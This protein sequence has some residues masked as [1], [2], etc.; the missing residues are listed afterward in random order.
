MTPQVEHTDV[1]AYALGLLEEDDRRAFEA[2]LEQCAACVAELRDMSGMAELFSGLDEFT[3]VVHDL[4]R[5]A[6]DGGPAETP[7][8]RSAVER[9]D[10]GRRRRAERRYRR[11]TYLI[12]AAAAAVLIGTGFTVGAGLDD[13]GSGQGGHKHS[14]AQ[15]LVVSGERHSSSDARTGASGL[16]GLEA[17]NWGTHVGLELKGVRGPLECRLEAVSRTGERTVVT[18]WRVPDKGYGVPGSPAPLITHGG[19]AIQRKD[20]DRFEVKI[21]GGGTLLTIPV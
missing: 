3:E 7:R 9:I 14:P 2:H 21:E 20:L 10:L 11:G 18:G 1:G 19:T 6:E 12:G 16:V 17:K 4:D 5:E 13:G 15:A 8:G